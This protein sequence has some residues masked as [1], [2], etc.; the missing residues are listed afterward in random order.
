MG[1]SDDSWKDALLSSPDFDLDEWKLT[2]EVRC[3]F[4]LLGWALLCKDVHRDLSRGRD[5]LIVSHDLRAQIAVN[6]R[7]INNLC[8]RHLEDLTYS[9][10]QELRRLQGNGSE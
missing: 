4:S 8:G 3:V 10:L 1:G 6:T 7:R 2:S 9:Q 5:E